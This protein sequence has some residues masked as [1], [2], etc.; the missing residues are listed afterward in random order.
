MANQTA[1][2][3][4]PDPGLVVEYETDVIEEMKPA[5]GRPSDDSAP[6]HA[7]V[8]TESKVVPAHSPELAEALFAKAVAGDSEAFWE[9]VSPYRGLIYSV[10]LAM[11]KDPER[12]EDQLHDVLVTAFRSLSNLRDIRKLASWLYSMSRYRALEFIRREQR[13]PVQVLPRS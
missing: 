1:K 12:A 8:T 2:K 6:R 4:I 5:G 13:R 11:L 10:A 7:A 3:H 9:L